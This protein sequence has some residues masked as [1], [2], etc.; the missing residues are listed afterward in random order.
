MVV[1]SALHH[2]QQKSVMISAPVSSVSLPPVSIKNTYGFRCKQEGWAWD[3]VD[4]TLHNIV[5]NHLEG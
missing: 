4:H 2:S 1:K 3:S 5:L